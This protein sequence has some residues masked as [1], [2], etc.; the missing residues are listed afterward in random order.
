MADETPNID[1]QFIDR[2]SEIKSIFG[3]IVSST[4]S[5]NRAL[6]AAGESTTNINSTYRALISSASKVGD[7]Q[8]QARKS[9]EGSKKILE[10]KRKIQ[11][12]ERELTAEINRLTAVAVTQTGETRNNTL[13]LAENLS[14]ARDEAGQLEKL[15]QEMA[16]EAARLDK[17]TQF[18]GI[19]STFIGS[20]PGL[21]AFAGPFKEAEEAAR[22][23][24]AAGKT[25][26]EG[27]AAG[28]KA[29][30]GGFKQMLGPAALIGGLVTGLVKGFQELIQLGFQVSKQTT[31]IGK[32]MGLSQEQSLLLRDTFK[33]ISASSENILVNT[34]SL[35]E[36]Q[37][38][39]QDSL[40]ASARFTRGQLED[41]IMLTKQVGLQAESAQAIQEFGLANGRTADDNLRAVIT[42]TAS[43]AKQTG[44]QLDN[45][46]VINDIAKVEGQLR[47]IYQ[48]NPGLIAKAVVQ[49]KQLGLTVEQTRKAAQGL[50]DFEQSI[51]NELEA[52]LLT[53][54]DL[55]LE[56]ARALALQGKT[57]E[58]T[59]EIARQVGSAAEFGRMNVVQ[60][61]AFANAVG[62]SADELA[63]SLIQRENLAKLGTQTRQEIEREAEALRKRGEVEKANQ[64]L[65][66]VGNEEEALA[67]LKRIDDQ[68]KFNAAVEKLKSLFADLAEPISR[69]TGPLV[70]AVEIMVK[71]FPLIAG[72]VAAIATGLAISAVRAGI[73]AVQT[74]IAAAGGLTLASVTTAGL[75]LIPIVAGIATGLAALNQAQEGAAQTA[76][77]AGSEGA[78]T[79]LQSSN[80]IPVKD[81]VL[82][83]LPE[84]TVV[85]AGGTRL[86]KGVEDKLDALIAVVSKGGNVYMDTNKVGQVTNMLGSYSYTMGSAQLG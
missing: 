30:A 79:A 37:S 35:V 20:I 6:R 65:A 48:N 57:V 27:F 7:L 81:Y 55:N 59:A 83:T 2:A 28:G 46:K 31:E 50:L 9:N 86:G 24:V 75:G 26:A 80:S 66:S 41:Q 68:A 84:D 62:L 71:A 77:Q 52:E 3:D 70:G 23:T 49:A 21:K 33:G 34:N 76:E 82:K 45:R 53:G 36:A 29:L 16:D 44:I 64:L 18:F 40:G 72:A 25:S 78:N 38:Q 73:L 5:L 11:S 32:S 13:K 1:P 74:S 54:K 69:I 61:E 47:L 85:G 17:S 63:N 14:N 4:A 67:A 42:Q 58:A 51:G 22:K 56:R 39:L 60:Q 8:E 19:A 15:Y 43:L 10:E 12:R